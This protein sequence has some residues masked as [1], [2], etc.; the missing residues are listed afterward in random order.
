MLDRIER[1]AHL[2]VARGCGFAALAILTF[3]VGLSFDLRMAFKS[4]GILALLTSAVL[5]L[6]A[7][8]ARSR[9]YKRTELWV[10]L[11]PAERPQAAIAQQVIGTVLRETY[12]YFALHAAV[13]AALMLAGAMIFAGLAPR[14]V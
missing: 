9:P 8:V 6:K 14:P 7:Q 11:N 5:L 1:A 12:L 2:S 4:A 13:V 3:F 10:M